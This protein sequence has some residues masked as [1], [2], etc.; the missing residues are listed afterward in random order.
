MAKADVILALQSDFDSPS[1]LKSGEYLLQRA[2]STVHRALANGDRK[3]V[4]EILQEWLKLFQEPQTML[5]VTIAKEERLSE[6]IPTIRELRVRIQTGGVFPTFYLR[7]VDEALS[8]IWL[9]LR[10]GRDGRKNDE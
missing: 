2:S 10:D 1:S 3:A 9:T 6:L 4:V 7:E 8:A 5:A